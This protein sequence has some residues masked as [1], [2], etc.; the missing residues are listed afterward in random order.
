M[1]PPVGW[2]QILHAT[3]ELLYFAAGIV[4]AVAAVLGLQ[5]LRLTRQIARTNAKREAIK[6]A[7]ERCQYFAERAV[8][9]SGAMGANYQRLGLKFLTTPFKWKIQ[10]GEIVEQDFDLKLLDTE[11]PKTVNVLV[12]YL[13]TL[14]AFA[15]PFVA[16]A[17]DD[18]L[19]Y[20]ETA[21]AFCAAVKLFM[22]AFFQ[23]RRTGAA[24]FE[25]TIKLFEL[26]NKRLVANAL[27]PAMKPI[28]ELFKSVE[29]ERIK[30]IGADEH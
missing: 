14:E 24:R 9:A 10:N 27:A 6:F 4:I 21:I 1:N 20:Q 15:I 16:G 26:W 25:S 22:P 7:A 5:Q 8:P 19:G 30:P 13:N 28:E 3:F 11:V 12:A 18:D 23:M 17:A 2:F 29:K